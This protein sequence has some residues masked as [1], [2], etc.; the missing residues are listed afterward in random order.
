MCL[1]LHQRRFGNTLGMKNVLDAALLLKKYSSMDWHYIGN[2]ARLKKAR[3]AVYFILLQAKIL[4]G[5]NIPAQAERVLGVSFV[6]RFVM[7]RIIFTRTF[8]PFSFQRLKR[9]CVDLQFLLCDSLTGAFLFF[10]NI[11]QEQFAQ[12]YNLPVYAPKTEHYYRFRWWYMLI[13]KLGAG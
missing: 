9:T 1:A 12:Y 11:S 10:F 3:A 5:Q 2:E 4:F 13:G 7:K 8:A 6:R